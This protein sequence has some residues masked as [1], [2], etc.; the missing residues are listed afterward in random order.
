[1]PSYRAPLDD[2]RFILNDLLGVERLAE[3]PGHADATPDVLLAVID[4]AAKFCTEVLFPLNQSGDAEGCR[5]Q[6]G[7]V[8][9]PAGFREAYK[10]FCDGGW[11]GLTA[12]P[13]DGGQGL[14][15]LLHFV[16]EE[17]LCSTNLSF[18]MFPGLTTGVYAGL[19]LHGNDDLKR[20]YLAKLASGEWAGTM[21]LTEGHAG[22]D[23][24]IIT[25]KATPAGDG[26]YRLTGTK[27]FISAG[28]HDLT[29]NIVHLVLAKLP[30]APPGTRG[31]SCFLV[32]KFL[33]T[34]EGRPGSRNTVT[35]GSIEHKMGIK[36]SPTCVLNF[37]NAIGWLLGEENK[38]MRAM[39]TL[40]NA[41]RLSVGIQGL[42]LATTSYQNA[43]AYARERLQGR[44][45]SGAKNTSGQ[46]DPIIQHA[47]VRRSLLTM[48]AFTEGGRALA[49]WVGMHIDLAEK[50][51][52]PATR[53][54]SDDLVALMT[55]VIKAY[56]TDTGF[57]ATNLGL[58]VFGGHGYVREHGMEQYVRDAR[59]G[60]IY[61]GTNYVQALD[62]IGRKLPE[63]GG[64]LVSG[65]LKEVGKTLA[66][67]SA[68]PRLGEIAAAVGRAVEAL[69]RSTATIAARG[70]KN[71][72]E[73]G[74]AASDYLRLF[75]LVSLGWLW[76]RMAA[77]AQA[78]LDAGAEPAAF[79]RSKLRTAR[80]FAAKVLPQ[81]DA[82]RAAI[83]AG[84]APVLEF[85][86]DDF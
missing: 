32:P 22:T 56:F 29:E 66:D 25:T 31:I 12:S 68:D 71:P 75:G 69:Q 20:R 64:R 4:E 3:L 21:C 33:P 63:G 18:G 85:E 11:P 58:Q 19:R 77:V 51:P 10:A 81:A 78:R 9:T 30:D 8:R 79:F 16:L 23:L 76:L 28:E 17:L 84:A 48:R 61:E 52:D 70:M 27:I 26:A 13:D 46:A 2:I 65:F 24:G 47:D 15:H 73:A 86:P 67:A 40:M 74:A 39:F 55:P 6:N 59:I 53:Q 54:A 83:E 14:P 37:D 42:G 43:V 62:L 60:Q 45:L 41:A 5:Y 80:F 7:E 49:Y 44:A 1:M 35:C 57:E 50:H 72:D 38:G 36:A 34:D 82:L